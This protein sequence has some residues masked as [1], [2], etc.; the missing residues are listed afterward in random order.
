MPLAI[1]PNDYSTI[2]AQVSVTL[3]GRTIME[4]ARNIVVGEQDI[5]TQLTAVSTPRAALAALSAAPP[6]FTWQ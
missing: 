1:A 4:G 5:R 3:T 6:P 2:V